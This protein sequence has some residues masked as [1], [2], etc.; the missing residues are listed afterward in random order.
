LDRK[1]KT[2][3][4]IALAVMISTAVYKLLFIRTVNYE[5]AGIRI[6]SEYSVVTGKVKPIP[7]YKGRADLPTL[8]PKLVKSIGLS[9]DQVTIARFRWAVFEQWVKERPEY[10]GWNTDKTILEKARAA[11]KIDM[12]KLKGAIILQ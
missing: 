8:E 6:P 3:L 2:I 11:F 10:N 9:E 12:S 7:N 1:I 5:I 4:I